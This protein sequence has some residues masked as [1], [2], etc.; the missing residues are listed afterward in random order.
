[1]SDFLTS[2]VAVV[3]VLGF[4]V[5]IHE[6]GHYAVAKWL[7]VRVE[8]FSIGFGKRLLGFR[9]G[10]TDYRISAIPLGGYVKMSGENPMDERTGD[11]A[12]FL[13]H[14]RWH[15]FLIAAAGPTMN[16]LLAIFLLTT[17]YMVHYEYP[18]FMDKPAVID[19][20]KPGSPAAQAGLQPGDRIAKIDGIV[21]PTWEQVQ[22]RVLISPNQPLAITIQRG[23]HTFD[24]TI[25]PKAVTSSEIGSAGWYPQEPV[26][27]GHLDDDMPAIKAGL[28]EGDR[29]IAMD[30]KP[31][32]S[33]DAMIERLQDTKS[34]PVDLTVLRSGE[35][36]TFH[37]QPVLSNTEDPKEQRYRLGFVNQEETT[38]TKLPFAQALKLSLEENRK[39]SLLL[40]ELAK[41]LVQGKVSPR[42]V[43]GP[44]GIAQEAGYAAEQKGWTPLMA[45]TAGISLNLGIFNLLPIPILDGGVILFLVIEGL[46]RR[47]V[48]LRIKER[49]YQAAF[50]F[51]VLFAVMVIYNDLVKTLPGLA[52][53][54]P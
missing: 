11:P 47:D 51:L 50:V 6:F 48:S 1:M 9:K 22:P 49:V 12:E 42:M 14:P 2:L 36:L 21:N 33:I 53:R 8:V 26:I 43:S 28:Q 35:T 31:L 52:E 41:K 38:V 24:R 5:L 25:V 29:V 44:I 46:M 4:M 19:Y 3:V 39:Y 30:G 15:R 13:S 7:G 37:L 32:G 23:D 18:V 40:L 20:V 16:I 54:L 27:I 45:L 34:K 10:D 17:V